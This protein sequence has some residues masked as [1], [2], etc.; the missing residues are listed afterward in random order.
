MPMVRSLS[1][2]LRIFW[3]GTLLSYIALFHWLRPVTYLASK[4]VGPLAQILFFTFLGTFATGRQNASFYIIGNAVQMA[5]V[6]GIFGVTMSIGGDRWAGTLAY[7]FGTPANRLVM[8]LGRAF[9]HII[10]GFVGVVIGLTWGALL[11]G[12]DF[13][14]TNLPLLALTILITTFSTS[15]LGLLMG[16][17]SLLTANVMFVNNT[18]YFA[19]LIFSGANVD[20]SV[21]PAWMQAISRALP[22]TRGIAAARALIAGQP[23]ETVI[24]LITGELLIGILYVLAGYLL[25]RWFEIQ[26]KRR[27]TLET[28]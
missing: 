17:L 3:E 24:P 19:L 23:V 13:S 25:F 2:N 28:V 4:V 7:L 8:F 11:L 5:A 9:I 20:I 22:L 21:L 16:C 6:S 15:G 14:Q 18:V 1:I 12:V 27:G 26:A 10:D